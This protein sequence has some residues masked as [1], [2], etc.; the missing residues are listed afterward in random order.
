V[1][2]ISTTGEVC[3]VKIN[4]WVEPVLGAFPGQ[5]NFGN[6]N[7]DRVKREVFVWNRLDPATR[8]VIEA[9]SNTLAWFEVS[10]S[11]VMLDV[12]GPEVKEGGSVKGLK[13]ELTLLKKPKLRPSLSVLADFTMKG[14]ENVKLSLHAVGYKQ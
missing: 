8:P 2:I 9:D 3:S 13:L 1:S 7:V 14:K 5:V 12:D 6:I 10:S 4:G 11:E